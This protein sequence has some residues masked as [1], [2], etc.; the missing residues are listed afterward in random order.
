MSSACTCHEDIS[1]CWWCLYKIEKEKSEL[2]KKALKTI[3]KETNCDDTWDFA[4]RVL[5]NKGNNDL[6]YRINNKGD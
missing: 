1:T 6:S 3:I 5:Q 2:Y 4:N